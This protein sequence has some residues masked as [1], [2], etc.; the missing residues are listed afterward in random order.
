MSQSNQTPDDMQTH[1][2]EYKAAIAIFLIQVITLLGLLGLLVTRHKQAKAG[3]RRILIAVAAAWPFLLV[4]VIY[5]MCVAFSP[6]SVFN[7][8]NPNIYVEAFMASLEEFIVVGIIVALGFL[9]VSSQPSTMPGKNVEASYQ[10]LDHGVPQYQAPS[11]DPRSG[12]ESYRHADP[13]AGRLTPSPVP[14]NRF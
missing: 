8:Q 12:Y 2:S 4:R 10:M 1:E 6:S 5:S 3:E 9:V 7:M 14:A 11:Y 13:A